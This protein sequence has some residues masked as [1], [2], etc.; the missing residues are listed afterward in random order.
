MSFPWK[1]FL[2]VAAAAHGGCG[3]G[4][5]KADARSPKAVRLVSVESSDGVETTT[6]SVTLAPNA[7]VDLAFRIAGYVVDVRRLKTA[8]GRSRELEPGDLLPSGTTLAR[9]RSS[10]YDAAVDKAHGARDEAGAGIAAAEATLAEAQAG[11]TQAE[12]DYGRISTLWQ[13]ESITKPAYD[14]ARARL[15]AARA[16]VDAAAAGVAAARQRAAA[17]VGQAH[18]AEIARS[19]T[20]LRAPF[21]AIL[22]ERR[23]DIGTLVSPAV[24]AF[25]IA[26][27]RQIKARF[28]A[29][30]TA[31]HRF[32]VGQ[33]LPLTVD[34]FPS[35]RFE[36][37]VLSIAPAADLKSRSFEVIVTIDNP[38]L[39]LRSGMIASVHVGSEATAERQLRIPIDGLVHDP[40]REQYLVYGLEQKNG[41]SVVKAIPIRPGPLVGNQVSVLEGLSAGQRIVS[42][43]ANLL[44][45]GDAVTEIR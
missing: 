34:A 25:T 32:H 15:D 43:G 11:L 4:D 40:D 45:P 17:A 3:A 16:K 24:P 26:D 29:P 18:E 30:D 12:F 22:L 5:V 9:V 14:G 28:N 35:D 31:L 27:L 37:H 38:A 19:D 42:P 21:D 8:D 23:I 6:Y 41:R 20:E 7:Q 1:S 2:L 39:K 33:L 36:G 13:Q 44:R 10:D